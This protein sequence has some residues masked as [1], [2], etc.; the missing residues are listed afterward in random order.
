[1]RSDDH[2]SSRVHGP[3]HVLATMELDELVALGEAL[4]RRVTSGTAT[5]ED[6]GALARTRQELARRAG[7]D[8]SA[9]QRGWKHD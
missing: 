5:L 3:S 6:F 2:H 4:E 8:R 7:D 1:M 9:R